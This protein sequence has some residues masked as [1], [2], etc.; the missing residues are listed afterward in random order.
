M[1]ENKEKFETYTTKSGAVLI[2]PEL[3]QPSERPQ[4]MESVRRWREENGIRVC[5]KIPDVE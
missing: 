2:N 1:N 5:P 3:E 4:V